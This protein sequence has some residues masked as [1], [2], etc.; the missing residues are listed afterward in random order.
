MI[1]SKGKI[2][3]MRKIF[4]SLL[5]LIIVSNLFAQSLFESAQTEETKESKINFD[6]SGFGRGV[7]Y[8]GKSLSDDL[9]LKNGVGEL[10]LKL[11][12]NKG[13]IA[14]LYSEIRFTSG[15]EFNDKITKFDVRELSTKPRR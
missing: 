7:M 10:A 13:S 15:F 14:S 3:T 5:F 1:M 6:I 8:T 9:E 12:A 11:K 2:N 4:L